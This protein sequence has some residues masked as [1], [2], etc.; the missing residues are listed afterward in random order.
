MT[1]PTAV[2]RQAPA[3]RGHP[4]FGTALD[5]RQDIIGTLVSQWRQHGDV[6]RFR[7][8][9]SGVPD[10]LITHPDDVKFVLQEAHQTFRH[11]PLQRA[12]FSAVVG[13]GLVASQGTYWRRQRRLAQPAFHKRRIAD[14][15]DLTVSTTDELVERWRPN[16]MSGEPLD[17]RVE[18]MRVTLDVLARALFSADWSRDVEKLG[19]HVT[20]LLERTFTG[21][22]SPFA[23]PEWA[24]TPVNRRFR[25][26]RDAVDEV[27]YRLIAAHRAS[28]ADDSSLVG[29]L[30]SAQDADT[31]EMMTDQQVRDEVMAM[32]IAGHETV[33]TA[34]T[35][36][37]YLLSRHPEAEARVAAEVAAVCGDRA[38][39]FEDLPSLEY[40]SRVIQESMRL[41]PPLWVMGRMPTEDTEI[42][43][44][45]VPRDSVVLL[46]Q[47]VTHRHPEFW[48]NPEGFDPDRFLP[49]AVKERHRYAYFP[50]GGGPRKCIGDAFAMMEMPLLIAR[51]IQHYRLQL[52]PGHPVEPAP[53]ISLRV[54]HGLPMTIHART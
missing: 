51:V 23:L 10:Y 31:G 40:T 43:G 16:S 35:W 4:I 6:V 22:L 32:L 27:V 12:T 48:D 24:P 47:Y 45:R 30:L 17:L 29:M 42:R 49:A 19:V 50:F 28:G 44:Y 14:F 39:T 37:W 54:A 13:Q 33:S 53:G 2:P 15:A 5:L 3:T 52:V 20:Y 8:P 38:P 41:Y 11:P 36:T 7:S 25:S 34:L 46:S 18:M 9:F 1:A 26:S 21:M